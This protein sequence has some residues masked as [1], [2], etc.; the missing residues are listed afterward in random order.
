MISVLEESRWYSSE[1]DLI[2]ALYMQQNSGLWCVFMSASNISHPELHYTLKL[3]RWKGK[4]GVERES[5]S[6][7]IHTHLLYKPTRTIAMELLYLAE[8]V[9]MVRSVLIPLP[10]VS[11]KLDN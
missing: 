10:N 3:E 1:D 7:P 11:N 4:W 6:T 8:R 9:S 5:D 2:S